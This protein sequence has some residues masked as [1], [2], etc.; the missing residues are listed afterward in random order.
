MTKF[1]T[2]EDPGFIA[3]AAELRRWVKR[4]NMSGNGEAHR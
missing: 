2:K 1:K 4:L 3:V